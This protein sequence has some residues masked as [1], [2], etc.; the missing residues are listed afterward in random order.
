MNDDNSAHGETSVA[1]SGA[2]ASVM[3]GGDSGDG[4]TNRGGL[5]GTSVFIGQL[6]AGSLGG[7]GYATMSAG[8]SEGESEGVLHLDSGRT[9]RVSVSLFCG[10]GGF[11]QRKRC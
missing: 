2:R 11:S 10:G 1:V 5:V 7:L 9:V 8:S 4:G 3:V 6:H